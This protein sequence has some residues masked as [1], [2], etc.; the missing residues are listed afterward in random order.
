MDMKK[1]DIPQIKIIHFLT[2][3]FVASSGEVSRPYINEIGSLESTLN[4]GQ[5]Q[6]R[7]NDFN[8]IIQTTE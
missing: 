8:A 7:M 2:E 4:S 3:I 1:Y 6:K 5:H